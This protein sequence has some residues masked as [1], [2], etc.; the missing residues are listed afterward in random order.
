MTAGDRNLAF[1]PAYKIRE[2]IGRKEVSAL[3]ITKLYLERIATL[4][5]D[6]N[7]FI[8]VA[9]EQALKAAKAAESAVMDGKGLG[10]LHGI[11]VSIKDL[12]ATKGIRITNGS[13]AYEHFVP[14]KDD[15]FVERLREAG[16]IIIG[17][18]NTPPRIWRGWRS[19]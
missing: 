5:P 15:L 2:M 10:L 4:D 8:T 18:T 9:E 16:A 6:L 19:D 1:T 13:L 11:P 12:A 3:E 17:K 14:D 7:A